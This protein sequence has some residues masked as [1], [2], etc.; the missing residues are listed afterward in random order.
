MAVAL[1]VALT[2][3]FGTVMRGP[4]MPV[5]MVGQPC[6]EPAAGVQLTFLRDG[7]VSKSVVT[8]DK[9]TYRVK[10]AAGVYTVRV[11][12]QSR[13][14]GMTPTTVTVRRGAPQRQNFAIDTGIR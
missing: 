11:S 8:T 2:G 9:G 13:I 7:V 3:L 12:P 10:L 5:C 14:G 6:S 1:A 4:T